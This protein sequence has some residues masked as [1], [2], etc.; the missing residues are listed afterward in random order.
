MIKVVDRATLTFEFAHSEVGPSGIR[1]TTDAVPVSA[2]DAVQQH[3]QS[4]ETL[5]LSDAVCGLAW[6]AERVL[7]CVLA[8]VG[9]LGSQ[10]CEI[11]C[12]LPDT[13]R[14]EET[15]RVMEQPIDKRIQRI[16]NVLETTAK[17]AIELMQ[18]IIVDVIGTEGM[19]G[20]RGL[21]PELLDKA[22]EFLDGP[23]TAASIDDVQIDLSSRPSTST[24]A[25]AI[26]AMLPT[27]APAIA[28]MLPTDPDLLKK[29]KGIDVTKLSRKKCLEVASKLREYEK[30]LYDSLLSDENWITT[31]TENLRPTL[32]TNAEDMMKE[33]LRK[34]RNGSEDA[35][36]LYSMVDDTEVNVQEIDR[37][38]DLEEQRR[39]AKLGRASRWL[40][41]RHVQRVHL[42]VA[43]VVGVAMSRSLVQPVNPVLTKIR[44]QLLVRQKLTDEQV[45]QERD[46][47]NKLFQRFDIVL[48]EMAGKALR[49][50]ELCTALFLEI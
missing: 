11:V 34:Y 7:Q 45:T 41:E 25:P 6:N 19:L 33:R 30:G 22:D 42:A 8:G 44:W 15:G 5:T 3:V 46:R 38:K 21:E 29:L 35:N 43:H 28:A 50:S 48:K 23:M 17:N 14:G 36:D 20:K 26:A 27:D 10:T 18:K 2:L 13:L 40:E 9:Q 12:Q 24:D 47:L 32:K 4:P 1:A 37:L 16:E 31:F 39:E 49:L